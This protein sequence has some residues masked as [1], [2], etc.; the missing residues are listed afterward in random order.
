[1]NKKNIKLPNYYY[2]CNICNQL[3]HVKLPELS[4]LMLLYNDV[5]HCYNFLIRNNNQ[6]YSSTEVSIVDR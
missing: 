2:I 5:K 4:P 3:L 1:M 6:I